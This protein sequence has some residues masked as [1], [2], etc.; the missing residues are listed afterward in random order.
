MELPGIRLDAFNFDTKV[1]SYLVAIV[2]EQ[3]LSRAAEKMYLSQPALSRYLRSV[4]ES[5]GVKLFTREHNGLSL[6]NAGKVFINGAR[7]MLHIAQNA[8]DKIQF[9]RDDR[10]ENLYIAAEDL[11]LPI[12]ER[13][14]RPA[15]E[16]AY[17]GVA[18]QITAH[19]G[20]EVRRHVADGSAD[21]GLFIGE[22]LESPFFVCDSLFSA[23]V[24]FCTAREE[25]GCL[26]ACRDGFSLKAFADQPVLLSRQ[27]TF[28]RGL[29]ENTYRS[30]GIDAPHVICEADFTVLQA[31]LRLGYG[32]TILPRRFAE[33]SVEPERIFS[34]A[35]P[36]RC[37]A[38]MARYQG[39][40]PS[41]HLQYC[42]E[43]CA[44]LLS[45]FSD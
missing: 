37:S 12:L 3:S 18:L 33:N 11:F 8:A 39:S 6:T 2:D 38:I 30:Y 29:Q 45:V 44:K 23:E 26:A 1:L 17:P 41:A 7:G 9:C 31:L 14:V 10:G 32:N 25:P 20:V 42:A 27:G 16:S 15:L 5:L 24:V 22:P 19:T 35:P 21:L 13:R 43:L 4:E 34:F 40:A 28:F 36:L